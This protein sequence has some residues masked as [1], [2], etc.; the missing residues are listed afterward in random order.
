[1]KMT[2]KAFASLVIAGMTLSALPFNA[3]A[4]DTV[5]HRLAGVDAAQTAVA[6]A[7][8]TGWTG[9]AILASSASYGMVDALTSG[10]LASFLKAPILLQGPGASLN[11]DTKDELTK[12]EV[13]T[14]YVTSGTAVISQSVLDE[15]EAMDITVVP[16][17][18]ADR[19]E[20]S[21][22]IAKKMVELGASIDKVAVA[23]GWLN[24]DALSIA[25]IASAQ[26]EPILLTEANSIPESV[27]KFLADNESVVSTDVIGGTAVISDDVAAEFPDA[28]RYYGNTAYDTNLEVLKAFD[29]VLEYDN[30]FIANGQTAIDALAGAPLAAQSNAGI[31]LTNGA[32]N[33]GTAYVGSKLSPDSVVTA[34]GGTAVVPD[35]VLQDLVDAQAA[36]AAKASAIAKIDGVAKDGDASEITA[37]DL[38]AAGVT[39]SDVIEA[40]LEAYQ[41]VIAA[42]ED[43]ALNSTEKIQQMVSGVNAVL[44]AAA[45]KEAAL[46]KIDGIAQDAD[47]SEITA[48]DLIAAGVNADDVI[49]ANL[50]AYRDEIS[51]AEDQALDST[52]EIQAMVADVNAAQA[53][54]A[55]ATAIAKIDGIALDGD[56]SEI[57]TQDLILAG[58]N[59]ADVMEANL[60]AYQAAI[61]AA[62]DQALD[63][64]EEIQAMVANVNA[65]QE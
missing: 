39:A 7:E 60:E 17:G 31:V 46:A 1:M 45:A 35:S 2:K 9:T 38:I 55:Q 40:N 57:G 11:K 3:L 64:T 36:A 52:E 26:T 50:D 43:S 23:Y 20:T 14:V 32:S 8:Q 13:K 27:Q 62:E 56:A 37:E 16:L 4:A 58:V 54:A 10:P 15:L 44:E 21:V 24:Q 33:E 22:N 51:A 25:S 63:S 61:S 42:V 47:A 49:E 53:T 5:S 48:Q 28:A 34:L 12:L 41:T 29:N 30:V 19:F 18:G 65:A 6:I 59:E